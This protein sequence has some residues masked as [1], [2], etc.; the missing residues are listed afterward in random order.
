VSPEIDFHSFGPQLAALLRLD[1]EDRFE[2]TVSLFDEWALDSLQA[3][4][5]IIVI[6]AMAGTTVPPPQLPEIFTLE[7]AYLYYLAVRPAD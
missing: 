6:E 3:F 2:P 5:M 1:D 4:E 7:D